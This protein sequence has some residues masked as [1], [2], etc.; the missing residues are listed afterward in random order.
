MSK[1]LGTVKAT[2]SCVWSVQAENYGGFRFEK[3]EFFQSAQGKCY[4]GDYDEA[5]AELQDMCESVVRRS[6]VQA[7]AEIRANGGEPVIQVREPAPAK[8][9]QMPS[10]APA[11][12]P[13]PQAQAAPEAPPAGG[14]QVGEKPAPAQATAG[15]ATPPPAP[16]K[17]PQTI[18]AERLKAQGITDDELKQTV[19]LTFGALPAGKKYY[20]QQQYVEAFTKAE[21]VLKELGIDKFR[22][23]L[24][25]EAAAPPVQQPASTP[26]PTAPAGEPVV[27]STDPA[28]VEARKQVSTKWPMWG[29]EL[30]NIASLWCA[31]HVKDAAA[32]D[33]V[34]IAA[35]ITG[36]TP[37]G[38][39]EAFLAIAR[40]IA[41]GSYAGLTQYAASAK[42]P[43]SMIESELSTAVGKPIRFALDIPQEAVAIE[44]GK[45][46]EAA[47]AAKA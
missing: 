1:I 16:E 41:I 24:K 27:F 42:K 17:K 43:M 29:V 45:M 10:P 15:P 2:A 21:A 36:T 14:Y 39:I 38:R 3:R 33:A 31:D 6:V 8:V 5:F 28:V 30:T 19:V 37:P 47:K 9:V 7:I 12:A 26:A 35:G 23:G 20:T 13:P 22:A 40:H 44:L 11:A 46:M 34:L 25:A 18:I 32:L 4:P